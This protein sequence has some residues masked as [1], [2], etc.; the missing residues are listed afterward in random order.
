M[1]N[2]HFGIIQGARQERRL[3]TRKRHK[4]AAIKK[5]K[6]R[7]AELLAC[8]RNPAPMATAAE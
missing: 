4:R 1:S 5:V 2:L 3:T 7:E 6:A 8:F